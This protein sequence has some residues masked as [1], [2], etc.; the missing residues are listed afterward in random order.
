MDDEPT[1]SRAEALRRQGQIDIGFAAA[2]AVTMMFGIVAA[3][4][5]MIVGAVAIWLAVRGLQMLEQSVPL[6]DGDRRDLERLRFQSR[7]ARQ[8]IEALEKTGNEPLRYD[9]GRCRQVAM[10]ESILRRSR[11]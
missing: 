4:T 11:T 3:G 8:L 2:I 6:D 5:A 10:L 1:L 9:L 7:Q